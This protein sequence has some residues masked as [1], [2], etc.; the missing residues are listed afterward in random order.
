M[1]SANYIKNPLLRG[2]QY[3]QMLLYSGRTL[4]VW[5]WHWWSRLHGAPCE[6]QHF[7]CVQQKTIFWVKKCV[8]NN[9]SFKS[10]WVVVVVQHSRFLLGICH[11]HNWTLVS[12]LGRQEE[13]AAAFIL[14]LTNFQP[15]H[16]FTMW[17]LNTFLECL[18][19]VMFFYKWFY[20][21]VL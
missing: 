10:K 18:C 4:F 7:W 21:V 16:R 9:Y 17:M 1:C 8:G 13:A 5:E 20:K 11:L 12:V 6:W 14:F 19:V 15:W 2:F 3:P